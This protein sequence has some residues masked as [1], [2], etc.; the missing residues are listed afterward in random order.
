MMAYVF[1]NGILMPRDQV[2]LDTYNRA[3]RYGDGVFE[4][5]R[6]MYG[7]LLFFK[8]HLDRLA[9][10][11]RRL[12][13]NFPLEET[14]LNQMALQLLEVHDIT[15]GARLRLSVW[16]ETPGRF[17]PDE[18][19]SGYLL[20]VEKLSN[21]EF[22]VNSNGL[23]LG[24]ASLRKTPLFIP[25]IKS[26]NSLFYV[27]CAREARMRQLDDMLIRNH[28]GQPVETTNS[29]IFLIKGDRILTP[30]LS[31]GCLPGIMRQSLL[32]MLQSTN[33]AVEET[34]IQ[35]E[36]VVEADELFLTNSILG[37]R[38]VG[39]F[40]KKRYF[41]KRS[42]VLTEQLNQYCLDTLTDAGSDSLQQG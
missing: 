13:I 14:Q 18:D 27:L 10:S 29:N 39:S 12:G 26:S 20:E 21:N 41:R 2:R 9:Y 31:S 32:H 35:I 38:W 4:T 11:L 17:M 36:D 28:Q 16:R 1:H 30:A 40:Q 19:R 8:R 33:V 24:E 3:F 25:E 5:M 23:R 15:G 7:Q 22:F 37:I 42:P 34:D 6:V